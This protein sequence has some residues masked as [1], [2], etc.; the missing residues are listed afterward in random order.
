MAASGAYFAPSHWSPAT[1]SHALVS[2]RV[3]SIFRMASR[4]ISGARCVDACSA[5]LT[6]AQVMTSLSNITRTACLQYQRAPV[7]GR[8]L[9]ACR[10]VPQSA[11]RLSTNI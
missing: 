11:T 5:Y 7:Y 1:P 6:S 3:S 10:P 4:R 8:N 2:R 9:V